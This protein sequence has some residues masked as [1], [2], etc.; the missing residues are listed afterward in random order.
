MGGRVQPYPEMMGHTYRRQVDPDA[1]ESLAAEWAARENGPAD[2]P[3]SKPEPPTTARIPSRRALP[4]EPHRQLQLPTAEEAT[5]AGGEGTVSSERRPDADAEA[6]KPEP[7]AAQDGHARP[8]D[9]LDPDFDSDGSIK[10]DNFT[11]LP[12]PELDTSDVRRL[13]GN[14]PRGTT[15]FD[16]E[17]DPGDGK[18]APWLLRELAFIDRYHE[19]GQ[20]ETGTGRQ[21]KL[22]ASDYAILMILDRIGLV[23]R[24]SLG[25]AALGERVALRTV[26]YRLKRL[27][28]AGLVSRAEISISKAT[29]RLPQIYALSQ[30]GLKAAQARV[31]PAIHPERKFHEPEGRTLT[32][33]HNHHALHWLLQLQE[34]LGSDVVTDYWR[35]DRY[36]TG[37][38]TP[39]QVGGGR[40]RHQLTL[41]DIAVPGGQ[42]LTGLQ[43]VAADQA[44]G[45]ARG[46]REIRPDLAIEVRVKTARRSDGQPG[47]TFDLLAEIDRAKPSHNR[48]KYLDYDGFLSGW[49][50]EHRRYR[51]LG[52]RPAVVVVCETWERAQQNAA[53]ADK[54]MTGSIGHSG[55]PPQDWYYPGRDHIFFMAEPDIYYESLRAVALHPWPPTLRQALGHGSHP[56][57]TV[58]SLLPPSMIGAWKRPAV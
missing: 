30:K 49:W 29:G 5:V 21:P 45:V 16:S 58:V 33:P 43:S 14:V 35:T 32:V 7:V 12:L 20:L 8:K 54:L 2:S 55:T 11:L 9:S 1:I 40:G 53:L 57:P 36:A 24:D 39:P 44:T 10:V 38:F 52:T 3:G 27:Y 19:C 17:T 47:L 42:M 51:A 4:R 41:S 6:L 50:S 26:Q 15:M 37:R 23:L 46:F 31:P 34:L 56:Q 13:V 22:A 25:R 18:Q 28:D 48:D